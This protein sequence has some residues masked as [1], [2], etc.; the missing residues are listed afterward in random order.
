MENELNALEEK[1]AQ[2]ILVSG[3]LRAENHSLRQE[4]ANALSSNR[5]C[6][7]KIASAKDR[8]ETLLST[9]PEETP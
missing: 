5:L 7:D 3:K 1:L 8:L 9:L 2:L 6:D 4:L